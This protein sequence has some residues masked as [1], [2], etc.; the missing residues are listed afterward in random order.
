MERINPKQ[1][2][3]ARE[4]GWLLGPVVVSYCPEESI[5]EM[6]AQ[7]RDVATAAMVE[8][9]SCNGADSPSGDISALA[10]ATGAGLVVLPGSL[11]NTVEGP[12]H[13]RAAMATARPVLLARASPGGPVITVA[14]APRAGLGVMAVAADEARRLDRPFLV[15]HAAEGT[16]GGHER[17]LGAG[18]CHEPEGLPWNNPAALGCDGRGSANPR[19]VGPVAVVLGQGMQGPPDSPGGLRRCPHRRCQQNAKDAGNSRRGAMLGPAAAPPAGTGAVVR[20]THQA[21]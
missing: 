9:R 2:G 5:D 1:M 12:R 17:R 7:A 20:G 16:V 14:G 11:M 21:T 8:V 4:A 18:E 13:L 19:S 6:L 15:V 10:A 3:T